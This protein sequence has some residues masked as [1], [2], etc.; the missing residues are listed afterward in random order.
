MKKYLI[1][2]LT[3][4][5]IG[6]GK[7]EKNI[8]NKVVKKYEDISSYS[9]DGT[10]KMFNGENTYSYKVNVQHKK[11]DLY[12]VQLINEVNNHEQII[13]RNKDGVYVLTPSLNKSFKF[14]SDWPY[15]NSQIY[16]INRLI[17][18]IKS[19]DGKILEKEK[20]DSYIKTKVNYTTNTD[21][22]N[23]RIYIDN[24]GNLKRV[25]VYDKDNIIAMEFVV[26]NLDINKKV[27]D[28]IFDLNNNMK[29]DKVD[30]VSKT[31]DDVVYP[32][33]LPDNTY[34]DKQETISLEDG[35]RVILTFN[36][37]KPF[38]L[39]EETA[40]INEN[41][42]TSVVMGYPDIII[43]TVGCVNTSTISWIS[44][45]VEYTILSNDLEN[46]ELFSVAKSISSS[47]ITK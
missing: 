19:D 2:V 3:I 7:S 32:M 24:D 8:I 12:K 46:D 40:T 31:I 5:L 15:N 45:G 30:A 29:N 10:L 22:Q 21:L 39:I 6:C 42:N 11:D 18:D 4:L 28:N 16:I 36:G 34:L 1:V 44:N 27:E 17:A 35:E 20:E 37:D 9:M 43:D 13:L 38:T 14:Q 26:N 41:N 23:Q 47:T 33:Y 25:E